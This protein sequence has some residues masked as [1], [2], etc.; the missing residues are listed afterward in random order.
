MEDC[1]CYETGATQSLRTGTP[2]LV[3]AGCLCAAALCQACRPQ[4]RLKA[5]PAQGVADSC[6]MLALLHQ[7]LMVGGAVSSRAAK[8][9]RC[10]TSAHGQPAS[11]LAACGLMLKHLQRKPDRDLQTSPPKSPFLTSHLDFF[12]FQFSGGQCH[13]RRHHHPPALRVQGAAAFP[14]GILCRSVL[15]DNLNVCRKS[16][17]LY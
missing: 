6:R 17:S 10:K 3:V 4:P 9:Q 14:F 2:L 15:V 7:R 1:A 5:H 13:G 8:E 11:T 16:V 12:L